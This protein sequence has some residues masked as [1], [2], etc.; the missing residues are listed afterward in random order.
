MIQIRKSTDRGLADHGWLKSRHTF[1]FAD[2][3]DDK[4]MGYRD[5]RVINEDR[6]AGGTG[7]G[8][9][10]HRDMEIISYVMSG[11]LKHEDSMGNVTTIRPGEVQVMSAGTGV[12]HAEM[13]GEAE[14][15]THFFQIWIL[16]RARGIKAGYGQKSF[17]AEL[18]R[19][20]LTLVAAGDA[21]DGAVGINQDADLYIARLQ[22]GAAVHLP[23]RPGRGYWVQV[24]RGSVHLGDDELTAGDGAAVEREDLNLKAAGAAEVLI[25]DLA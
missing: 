4:F 16:P 21:R 6:I 9:H 11:S 19:Q 13:N 17:A 3:H 1:S 5:L 18:D 7:F 12:T 10:A 15:D 25:F 22:S 14:A 20:P 24:T 23:A 8:A 2:Y